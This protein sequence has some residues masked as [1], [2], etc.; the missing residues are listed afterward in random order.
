MIKYVRFIIDFYVVYT[1]L[2]PKL[3]PMIIFSIALILLIAFGDSI[4]K[5]A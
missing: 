1:Y 2:Y 4:L 5:E 3:L